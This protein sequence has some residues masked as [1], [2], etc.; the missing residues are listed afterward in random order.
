ML[1]V[2]RQQLYNC[3]LLLRRSQKCVLTSDE[4]DA[5]GEDLLG[6]GVRRHVAEADRSEAAKGEVESGDVLG[7]DRRTAGIVAGE[8]VPL[9]GLVGQLVQPTDRLLQVGS[10]VVADGVPDAGE[11]VSDEDES[12]HE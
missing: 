5:D 12:G 7:P 10:L 4:H 3:S 2:L 6:V 8:R 11:P 9:L 1:S